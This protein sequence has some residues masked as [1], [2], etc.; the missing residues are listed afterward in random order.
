MEKI[1][2]LLLRLWH[3]KP[4]CTNVWF[5]FDSCLHW[6]CT[7]TAH[8]IVCFPFSPSVCPY[9]R[10]ILDNAD[11]WLFRLV[12]RPEHC[13]YHLYTI[14]SC[15]MELRHRGHNSLFLSANTICIKIHLYYGFCAHMCN[16]FAVLWFYGLFSSVQLFFVVA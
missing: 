10:T 14:N 15:S 9:S 2:Y 16:T 5:I 7:C 3:F 1:K 11:A 6:H 13:L 12:Q 4:E 8:V